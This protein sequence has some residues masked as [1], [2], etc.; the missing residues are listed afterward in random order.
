MVPL[1]LLSLVGLLDGSVRGSSLSSLA[2][3]LASIGLVCE[4][5]LKR[6]RTIRRGE[7]TVG[8]FG[9][10]LRGE[11][12]ASRALMTSA[13]TQLARDGT[14]IV[15]I[16]QTERP[17]EVV[18]HD[19]EEARLVQE[20]LGLTPPRA[21]RIMAA[22]GWRD[23][24][25]AIA[26]ILLFGAAGIYRAEVG[27]FSLGFVGTALLA[28]FFASVG[29]VQGYTTK[30]TVAGDGIMISNAFG[31][32]RWLPMDEIRDLGIVRDELSFRIVSGE[33]I[34]KKIAKNRENEFTAAFHH[35]CTQLKSTLAEILESRI[36]SGTPSESAIL[37]TP[38]ADVA[39]DLRT[40]R[41]MR[42]DGYRGLAVPRSALW[43][44]VEDTSAPPH[45]RVRAAVALRV[46]TDEAP[47]LRVV[48]KCSAHS[49]LADALDAVAADE[50]PRMKRHLTRLARSTSS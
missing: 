47:H 49:D 26:G 30:V 37:P 4:V 36:S 18:V 7:V 27:F 3:V 6:H 2:T 19:D 33:R 9:V 28:A 21:F 48:A 42:E 40:L 5:F 11:L 34:V 43:A 32:R 50:E 39:E 25:L 13:E 16:E 12:I 35:R 14:L 10:R 41:R 20:A 22:I 29:F 45:S 24:L 23:G 8:A 46:S 31:R 1:W 15:R 38:V 17:L 44:L